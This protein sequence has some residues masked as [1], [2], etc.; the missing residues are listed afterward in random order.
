LHLGTG[1]DSAVIIL[2]G[3]L[4]VPYVIGPFLLYFRGSQPLVAGWKVLDEA[5]EPVGARSVELK[6]LGFKF[7]G[8]L[9]SRTGMRVAYFIHPQNKDSAEVIIGLLGD[10]L[11][12]LIFKTRFEDDFALEVGSTAHAPFGGA[13]NPRFHAFN[14]PQLNSTGGLYQAHLKLK[15]QYLNSRRPVIDDG[16]GELFEFARKAEEVH[17]GHMSSWGYRL[18]A[19]RERFVYT[20]PGAIRAGWSTCWPTTTLRKWRTLNQARAKIKELGLAA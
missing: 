2:L 9:L 16:R 1:I 7:T 5:D 3:M 12:T 17:V 13:G 4:L 14:F 20:L 18:S 15:A 10:R 6:N 8:Y 11:D 19:S